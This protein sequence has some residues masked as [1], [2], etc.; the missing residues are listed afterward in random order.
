MLFH[1]V[2]G[3]G[4]GGG[5]G[6]DRKGGRKGPNLFRFVFLNRNF[7]FGQMKHFVVNIRL[8]FTAFSARY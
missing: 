4:A 3:E 1:A 5:K 8:R 2:L 7:E 6:M